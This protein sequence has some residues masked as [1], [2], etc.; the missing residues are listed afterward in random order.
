MRL[1]IK[2]AF[3]GIMIIMS[4]NISLLYGQSVMLKPVILPSQGAHYKNGNTALSW[5]LGEPVGNTFRNGSLVLKQG[6]QQP[7]FVFQQ[8]DE[9][10]QLIEFNDYVSGYAT[11][12][13]TTSFKFRVS[14][15]SF[16]PEDSMVFRF[17]ITDTI[18]GAVVVPVSDVKLSVDG[19]YYIDDLSALAT[20]GLYVV[21]FILNDK[22][23]YK[24]LVYKN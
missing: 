16:L 7:F 8:S 22:N 1:M 14:N 12:Y 3:C 15:Y 19:S 2:N 10:Y 13:A 20:G 21:E 9:A 18:N 23:R 11:L 5:T 17:E 4:G 6:F 24:F